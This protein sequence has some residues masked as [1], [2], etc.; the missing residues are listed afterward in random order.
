MKIIHISFNGERE[1]DLSDGITYHINKT[2]ADGEIERMKEH[3]ERQGE[4]ITKLICLLVEQKTIDEKFVYD[5]IS[6]PFKFSL[7]E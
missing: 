4:I 6:F 3:I 1:V 5:M 2:Y 7:E